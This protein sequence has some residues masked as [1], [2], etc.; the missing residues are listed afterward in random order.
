M[1]IFLQISPAKLLWITLK[2]LATCPFRISTRTALWPS[3]EPQPKPRPEPTNPVYPLLESRIVSAKGL[4]I[5]AREF[6]AHFLEDQVDA[7]PPSALDAKTGANY[8][9][10]P[11]ARFNLISTGW[12]QSAGTP[13]GSGLDRARQSLAWCGP[14]R[15]S[16]PVKKPWRNSST[17][18]AGESFAKV[19]PRA[20]RGVRGCVKARAASFLSTMI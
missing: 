8:L 2:W 7:P 13:P 16:R 15:S 9:V 5:A 18:P 19:E 17:Q 4:N 3:T 10:G 12:P 20:G 6:E 11:L 1:T 14:W